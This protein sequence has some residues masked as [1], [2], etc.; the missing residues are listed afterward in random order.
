MLE[1]KK[2]P[3]AIITDV[4][5]TLTE[6]TT[7]YELTER[8]GASPYE[9]ADLFM[10]FLRGEISYQQV[11]KDL[12]KLWNA[13]GPVHKDKLIE[14]FRDIPLRGDAYSVINS[15][16]ESGYTLCLISGSIEMFI[17]EIAKRFEIDHYYGNSIFRFDEKGYWV[18]LEY[19]KD[20]E[21]LKMEQFEDFLKKTGFK[22]EECVAIGDGD[23]DLGI[24][25]R[26]PGI[27]VNP[28]SEHLKELAWQ[29]VRYLP[30]VLQVLESIE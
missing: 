10:K 6:R 30:R 3:K 23:N 11:K 12:F 4:D 25:S 14:I 5:S 2:K 17:A 19:T 24:F 22:P 1:P 15:L 13:N 21:R 26:I 20:E 7:W 16:K 29:E 18:D 9:H 28:K 27:V 8:L